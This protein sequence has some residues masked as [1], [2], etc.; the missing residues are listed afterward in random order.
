MTVVSAYVVF[1]SAEEANRIG[2]TLIEERLA[3]CINILAP[4]K[5]IYRWEGRVE[6]AEETPA[7]LKTDA[8][9]AEALIARIAE[10]HSYEVPA[11]T[12]WPVEKLLS[13]YGDWVENSCG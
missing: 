10:M 4:C 9:L 13:S 8:R 11:I 6:E 12:I 5:S 1:G 7:I 3:A 2:R